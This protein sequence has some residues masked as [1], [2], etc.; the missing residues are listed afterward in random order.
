MVAKNKGTLGKPI[1]K[2]MDCVRFSYNGKILEGI[3]GI[4]DSYGTMEQNKEPSYD[5]EVG[6]EECTLY[7]H[8][9]ESEI[10]CRISEEEARKEG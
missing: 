8:I 1:Y 6:G 3:I 5:I 4:V 10:I 7:K 2:Y 9:L